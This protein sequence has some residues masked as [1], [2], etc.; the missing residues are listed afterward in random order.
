MELREIARLILGLRAF[1]FPEKAITDLLL[2]V[3]TG[4]EQYKA[5]LDN[6]KMS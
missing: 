2:W 3:G 1:R 6:E 5:A 4:D